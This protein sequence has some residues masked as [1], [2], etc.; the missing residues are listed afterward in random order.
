MSYLQYNEFLNPQVDRIEATME[1]T[2]EIRGVRIID[3]E[4]DYASYEPGEAIRFVLALQTYQGDVMTRKGKITIP[5]DLFSDQIVLRAYG[6]PRYLE[7]GEEPKVITGID[8][9]ISTIESFPGYQTLTV[10]LFAVDP[11]SLYGDGLYGV[12]EVTFD[13][14]GYVVYGEREASALLLLTDDGWGSDG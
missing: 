10:E 13:F 14:P 6:G 8:D 12:D 7:S 11:F 1:F 2:E 5:V 3:L 9:L 4:I